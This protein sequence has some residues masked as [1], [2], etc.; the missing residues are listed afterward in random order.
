MTKR[1]LE[2]DNEAEHIADRSSR[3]NDHLNDEKDVCYVNRR[4]E[5]VVLSRGR[6]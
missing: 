5:F 2:H 1:G 6:G 4:F 3:T